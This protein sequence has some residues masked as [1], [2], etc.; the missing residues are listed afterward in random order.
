MLKYP[1][2]FITFPQNNANIW[3]AHLAGASVKFYFIKTVYRNQCM[4]YV[5]VPQNNIIY[6]RQPKVG[7][8]NERN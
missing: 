4:S 2:L 7:P 6:T 5:A 3:H 8:W 1:L